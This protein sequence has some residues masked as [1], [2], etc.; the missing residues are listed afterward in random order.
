MKLIRV[1]AAVLNQIPLDWAGNESR[2]REAIRRAKEESA[3]V[4]CLPEL[5]IT[6]YGCEDAFHAEG[7]Q[8]KALEILRRLACETEGMI[9]SFGLPLM[10]QNALFDVVCVAAN[11]RILGFVAKH[12]LNRWG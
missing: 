7:T 10:L 3:A 8:T 1:A 5:C 6:G 12:D 9:A 4:L 2:M 11:G